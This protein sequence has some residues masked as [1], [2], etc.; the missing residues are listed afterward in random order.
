MD[1]ITPSETICDGRYEILSLLGTGGEGAVYLAMDRTLSRKVA[2]KKISRP[3]ET[4]THAKRTYR[5]ICLLKHINHD[6]LIQLCDLFS[7]ATSPENFN[8][9]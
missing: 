2:I 7:R 6:N 5:E 3:F 9:M 1:P 8:D 4:L